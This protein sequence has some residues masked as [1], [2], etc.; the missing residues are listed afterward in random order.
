MKVKVEFDT[1]VFWAKLAVIARRAR[2][3][4]SIMQSI[5]TTAEVAAGAASTAKRVH[6][7][8]NK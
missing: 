7:W 1:D 5:L 4:T 2:N 6:A 8:A 3:V